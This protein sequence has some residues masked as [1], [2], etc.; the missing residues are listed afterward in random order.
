MM[1]KEDFEHTPSN[2]GQEDERGQTQLTDMEKLL[3]G[4]EAKHE[5]SMEL[6]ELEKQG[7]K[8]SE[9]TMPEQDLFLKEKEAINQ[10]KNELDPEKITSSEKDIHKLNAGTRISPQVYDFEFE[11]TGWKT[12][13]QR[14]SHVAVVST[15]HFFS[16]L[17]QKISPMIS[18]LIENQAW[19][20]H[21]D[22]ALFFDKFGHTLLVSFI[23]IVWIL[24]DRTAR[25]KIHEDV[26][27]VNSFLV[28]ALEKAY[29]GQTEAAK[30]YILKAAQMEPD[31]QR[32]TAIHKILLSTPTPSPVSQ[33]IKKNR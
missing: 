1:K 20:K 27:R 33:P 26:P 18:N 23:F 11:Q 30:E 13:L 31:A 7:Q 10:L 19:L 9:A 12:K 25:P 32:A 5:N 15:S 24:F 28:Q 22:V 2:P 14:M 6:D 8:K 4:K 3:Q 29:T 17:K 16:Q 21:P